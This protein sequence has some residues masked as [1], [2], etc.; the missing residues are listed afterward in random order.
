MEL[1]DSLRLEQLYMPIT[2]DVW[3]ISSQ[4]IYPS[5]KIFGFDA[6]GSFVNIYSNFDIAP[7]FD[8]KVF[9][10]TILKY[11]DSSNKKSNDYWEAARPVPLQAD[12]IGRAHV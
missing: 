3:A 8:K 11:T 4:V 1:I 7:Q 5:V 10:N 9:N 2:K 6:Y 12:E